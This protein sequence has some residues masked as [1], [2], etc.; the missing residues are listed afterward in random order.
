MKEEREIPSEDQADSEEEV[1]S[2]V[3]EKKNHGIDDLETSKKES[4]SEED[5]DGDDEDTKR[6]K[7]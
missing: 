4:S 2:D 1:Y 6:P 5:T 7:K 3:A